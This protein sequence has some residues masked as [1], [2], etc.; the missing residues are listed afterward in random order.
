VNS[1]EVDYM[2]DASWWCFVAYEDR[3]GFGSF[4]QYLYSLHWKEGEIRKTW[5]LPYQ[6]T[7]I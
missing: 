1:S 2:W 6:Y 5:L 3:R 4:V 7:T